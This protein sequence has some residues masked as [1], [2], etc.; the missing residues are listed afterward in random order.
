M[1]YQIRNFSREFNFAN[2]TFRNISRGLNFK[3]QKPRK[4]IHLGK[5]LTYINNNNGWRI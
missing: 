2:C 5:S 1:N 3:R 4:L